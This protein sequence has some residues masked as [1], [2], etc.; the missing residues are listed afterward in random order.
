MKHESLSYDLLSMVETTPIVNDFGKNIE[1]R[2][3]TPSEY[4]RTGVAPNSFGEFLRTLRLKPEGT[5]IATSYG[6]H[7]S[8]N[9]YVSIVDLPISTKNIQ[10]SSSSVL[11]LKAEFLFQ[12]KQF[13]KIIFET[14]NNVYSF[15]EFA[16]GNFT[17]EKLIQFLDLVMSE[18]HIS[19]FCK[20]LVPVKINELQIGDVFVQKNMPNGHVV[21]VVDI[22]QNRQ[23][24]K[25]FLLA[26]SFT[27]AQEIQILSNPTRDDLSPW[28]ELKEGPLLTPEWRFMSSDLMRFDNF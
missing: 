23:G 28:Y 2:F 1:E 12:Q 24:Q 9:I 11:R 25:V 5:Q 17:K 22:A 3:G 8:N 7:T 13:D 16:D 21:I 4:M 20:Q 18:I 19:D 10:I 6:Q 14:K 26:Q 27:P 15:V